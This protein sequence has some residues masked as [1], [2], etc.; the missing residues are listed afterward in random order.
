MFF[1]TKKVIFIIRL[2][3]KMLNVRISIYLWGTALV[4][5]LN[6]PYLSTSTGGSGFHQMGNF[7]ILHQKG[8]I[9]IKDADNL[10]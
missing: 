4:C 1:I 6:S 9:H 7:Q 8:S 5:C 10:L 2:P 3:P